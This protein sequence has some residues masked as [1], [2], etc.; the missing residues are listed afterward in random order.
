MK[1]TSLSV[2]LCAL[3]AVAGPAAQAQVTNTSLTVTPTTPV[4]DSNN[5]VGVPLDASPGFASG[6]F[7]SNGVD[8]TDMYF[9][10]Q[11]LFGGRSITLGEIAGISYWT[12]KGATHVV[13]PRDWYL[14]IYSQP[15]AGDV[16]TPGWYGVRIGSEPYFSAGLNDP[17]NTWNQWTTDGPDNKLRFFEST[18]GAPG[19]TFGNFAEKYVRVSLAVDDKAV[20]EGLDRVCSFI[21][22]NS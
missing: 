19:A 3:L 8:K 15:F 6:S 13:D 20:I 14:A 2:V 17:A 12:K 16:S 1:W 22:S 4:F 21:K 10:P 9:T 5:V 18:A 7:A 11:T